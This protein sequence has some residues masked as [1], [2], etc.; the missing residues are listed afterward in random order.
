MP[1]HSS[2]VV[3]LQSVPGNLVDIATQGPIP[4]LLLL[5]GALLLAVSVGVFGLLTLAAL[6]K[7]LNPT[8]ASTPRPPAE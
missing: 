4:A 1:A 2:L 8:N 5:V 3:S 6:A 7:L